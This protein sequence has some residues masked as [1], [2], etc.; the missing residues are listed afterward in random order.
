MIRKCSNVAIPTS[1]TFKR[2]KA[3]QK[4]EQPFCE[5]FSK[6]FDQTFFMSLH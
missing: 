4:K 5:K 2:K 1:D 3:A 6:R